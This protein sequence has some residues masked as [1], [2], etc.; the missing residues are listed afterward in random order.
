MAKTAVTIADGYLNE[1]K[2]YTFASASSVADGF[3]ITCKG[4]DNRLAFLIN[5]T[6]SNA[7]GTITFKKGD[8]IQGVEDIEY[9][10]SASTTAFVWIDSGLIKNVTGTNKGKIVAIPS[11]ATMKLAAIHLGNLTSSVITY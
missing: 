2:D 3:E 4:A 11:A 6:A 5:N 10:V 1:I 7:S 9:T 8:A